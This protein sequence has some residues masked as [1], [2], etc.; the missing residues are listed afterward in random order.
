M[1]EETRRLNQDGVFG[2][3]LNQNFAEL[4]IAVL[5]RHRHGDRPPGRVEPVR[6]VDLIFGLSG[7]AGIG[8]G[9]E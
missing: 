5:Q 9:K 3:D 7:A 4:D 8:V 2:G 1:L 6:N